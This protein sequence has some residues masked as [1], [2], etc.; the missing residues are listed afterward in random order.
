MYGIC[1]IS[2]I[3]LNVIMILCGKAAMIDL[4]WL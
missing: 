3:M 1:V 2:M 4:F